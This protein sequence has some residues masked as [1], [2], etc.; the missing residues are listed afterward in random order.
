[1]PFVKI[2][3][4]V[5]PLELEIWGITPIDNS[6]ADNGIGRRLLFPT[7]LLRWGRYRYSD[8]YP[9][10]CATDLGTS[11][12]QFDSPFLESSSPFGTVGADNPVA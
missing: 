10:G 1:M 12:N 9:M 6:R 7:F 2:C 11:S 3:V 8:L 5:N 4:W